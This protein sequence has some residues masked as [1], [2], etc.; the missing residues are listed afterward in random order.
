MGLDLSDA[1]IASIGQAQCQ[2]PRFCRH[3]SWKKDRLRGE[4]AAERSVQISDIAAL[5]SSAS[6]PD[7]G[8]RAGTRAG[9]VGDGDP[10]QVSRRSR[11]LSAAPSREGAARGWRAHMSVRCRRSNAAGR[12]RCGGLP[13]A[14]GPAPVRRS[15]HRFPVRN[16]VAPDAVERGIDGAETSGLDR[17]RIGHSVADGRVAGKEDNCRVEGDPGCY[18]GEISGD[19]RRSKDRVGLQL[20][21]V[22]RGLQGG[23]SPRVG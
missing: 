4:A 20:C 16:C 7:R 6:N 21:V 18:P 5:W 2:D 11:V 19:D 22:D 1:A 23:D 14:G 15:P 10:E 17:Q 3:R 12:A 8:E 13:R 9:T